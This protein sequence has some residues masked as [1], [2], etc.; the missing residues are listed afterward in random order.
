MSLSE[1]CDIAV[2]INKLVSQLL[3]HNE[4]QL[5]I[6]TYTDNQSLYNSAHTLKQTLEKRLLLDISAIREMVE[7]NEYG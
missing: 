6:T 2:D 3:L 5:N 7:R 4:K 1:G